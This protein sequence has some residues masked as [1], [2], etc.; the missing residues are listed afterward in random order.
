MAQT[1]SSLSIGAPRTGLPL[2]PKS[3][4][5]FLLAVIAVLIIALLSYQSLRATAS[6]AQSLAQSVAVLAELE[7]LLSTLKDAETGQRGYLLTG[8]ERYLEPYTNAR[9]ELPGEL[10]KAR[11]LLAGRAAQIR[12]FDM[13]EI[14]AKQK[15]DEL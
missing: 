1:P 6:S 10:Q 7:S 3:I 13:L 8:D 2:P 5:G 9:A 11:P 12:R 15:M 4:F 14:V